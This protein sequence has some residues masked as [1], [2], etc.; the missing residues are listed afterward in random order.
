VGLLVAFTVAYNIKVLVSQYR[1]IDMHYI[2]LPVIFD[3]GFS[4]SVLRN[5]QLFTEK[6]GG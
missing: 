5:K 3:G 6:G 2:V 4:I 1:S